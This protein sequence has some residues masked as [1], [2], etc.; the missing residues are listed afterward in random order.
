MRN[1][2]CL[3]PLNIIQ[4]KTISVSTFGKL[5]TSLYACKHVN[6]EEAD[7]SKDQLESFVDSE[8]KKSAEEFSKYDMVNDCL[9]KFSGR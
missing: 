8:A 6:A 5:V 2:A 9:N 7:Q 3:V 1:A 4:K